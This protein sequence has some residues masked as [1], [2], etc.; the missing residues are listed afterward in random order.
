MRWRY[1]TRMPRS[2][3]SRA[4]ADASVL[5]VVTVS[6]GEEITANLAA[7][8][9]INMK[10]MLGMQVILQDNR[11]PIKHPLVAIVEKCAEKTEETTAKA[12]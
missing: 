6:S 9:V 12:A 2:S 4:R 8:V 1:P 3:V 10:A 7:P 5:V 11:Y